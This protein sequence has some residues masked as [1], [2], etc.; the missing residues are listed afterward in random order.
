MC[1]VPTPA[2]LTL[3]SGRQRGT[4]RTQHGQIVILTQRGLGFMQRA[5]V[6]LEFRISLAG[7]AHRVPQ[8]FDLRPR[9]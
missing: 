2:K 1:A 3:D 8:P 6:T 9:R 5:D 4:L 7:K